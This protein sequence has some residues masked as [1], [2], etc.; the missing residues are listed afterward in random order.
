MDLK[1]QFEFIDN[2]EF[3]PAIL[4]RFVKETN[5]K[6]DIY[7]CSKDVPDIVSAFKSFLKCSVKYNGDYPVIMVS[8][9]VDELWHVFLLYSREYYNFCASLGKFIH[10]APDNLKEWGL[11]SQKKLEYNQNKNLDLLNSY[12]LLCE[13]EDLDCLNGEIPLIFNIDNRFVF[14]SKQKYDT[15]VFK[16]SLEQ[17]P[18][19][20]ITI[21]A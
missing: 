19:K 5:E 3:H 1:S 15:I 21:G 16:N 7:I 6:F 17:E 14:D 18:N 20:L 4:D 9:I 8:S 2:Y 10:H 13:I 12:Q 11:P